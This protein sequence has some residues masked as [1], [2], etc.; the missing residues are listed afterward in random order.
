M[1]NNKGRMIF[2]TCNI[3]FVTYVLSSLCAIE[4]DY[5]FV[6]TLFINVYKK[7]NVDLH[8]SRS[9]KRSATIIISCTMNNIKSLYKTYSLQT[10]DCLNK[11][12]V[13]SFNYSAIKI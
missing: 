9:N 4:F 1:C 12:N 13:N 10:R 5:V 2:N 7:K 8:Y 11:C 3:L 6:F